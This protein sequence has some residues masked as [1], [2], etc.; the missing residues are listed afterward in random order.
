MKKRT[1]W[2]VD[3]V[4]GAQQYLP[5]DFVNQ[6]KAPDRKTDSTSG[7][8]L[9]QD[10]NNGWSTLQELDQKNAEHGQFDHNMFSGNHSGQSNYTGNKVNGSR[11]GPLSDKQQEIGKMILIFL[12]G[13]IVIGVMISLIK[14]GPEFFSAMGTGI[15]NIFAAITNI[16]VTSL[17]F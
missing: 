10:R 15:E 8:P 14:N 13:I 11:R 6:N 12:G 7:L 5:E 17:F 16:I 3:A 4:T 9:P 2:S 1:N